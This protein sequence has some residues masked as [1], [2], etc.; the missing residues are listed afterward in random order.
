MTVLTVK[1]E[2]DGTCAEL[3]VRVS[4]KHN[5]FTSA[6]GLIAHVLNL[7]EDQVMKLARVSHTRGEGKC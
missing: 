1:A 2:H 3:S 6:V 7:S 5:Q 4:D